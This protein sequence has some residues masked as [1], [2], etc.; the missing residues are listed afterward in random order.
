MIGRSERP[1]RASDEKRIAKQDAKS[2]YRSRRTPLLALLRQEAAG[3]RTAQLASLS[4]LFATKIADARRRLTGSALEAAI[5]ALKQE[6]AAAE[7]ELL[8]TLAQQARQ[9][10]GEVLAALRVTKPPRQELPAS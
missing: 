5:A 9:R 6:Q 8:A 2:T 7:R 1:S 3:E 10:R 4:N